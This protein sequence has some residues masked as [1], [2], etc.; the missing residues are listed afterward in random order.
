MKINKENNR[1][2]IARARRS[3]AKV[4]GTATKPRL[5]VFRSNRYIY[6]QL[7]DDAKG[8]TLAAAF[9]KKPEVAGTELAA[10]AVTQGITK[11]VFQ[12][13]AYKYHGRVKVLADAARKGGLKF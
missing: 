8:R 1:R 9:G 5:S 12:K 10:K 7:I 3:R 6:S 4:V 11:V 2:R 13:G